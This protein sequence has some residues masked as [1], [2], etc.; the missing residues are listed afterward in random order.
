MKSGNLVKMKEHPYEIGDLVR[1]PE[2]QTYVGIVI[3]P[4][5]YGDGS[6]TEIFWLED[7]IQSTW[8][9][10]DLELVNAAR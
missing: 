1:Y 6:H 4:D 9:N 8:E 3:N 10:S 7:S 2:H 5:P